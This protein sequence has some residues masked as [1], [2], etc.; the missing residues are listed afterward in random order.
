MN[1]FL[2]IWIIFSSLYWYFKVSAFQ[3]FTFLIKFMPRYSLWKFF[4]FLTF[5][6]F[7][8][9]VKKHNRFLYINLALSAFIFEFKHNPVKGKGVAM[10]RYLLKWFD[11]SMRN[12]YAILSYFVYVWKMLCKILKRSVLKFKHTHT[13]KCQNRTHQSYRPQ[14]KTCSLFFTKYIYIWCRNNDF[15]VLVSNNS[16]FV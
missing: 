8:V 9:S 10:I 16:M 7:I 13:L 1:I 5:W 2:F 3:S 14:S 6:Y 12:H 15:K 4:F 11:E